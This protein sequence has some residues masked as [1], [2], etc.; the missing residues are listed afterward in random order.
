MFVKLKCPH[1]NDHHKSHM[2]YLNYKAN[3]VV[4]QST[5]Q[6]INATAKKTRMQIMAWCLQISG[7]LTYIDGIGVLTLDVFTIGYTIRWL[8]RPVFWRFNVALVNL[9]LTE[10]V[11]EGPFT[12]HP[13]M[14]FQILPRKGTCDNLLPNQ[15]MTSRLTHVFTRLN[16]QVIRWRDKTHV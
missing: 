4:G 6:N 12:I 14:L 10:F 9:N 15:L 16:I 13:Y 7:T 3:I 5:L 11:L 2:Q 1:D 8:R